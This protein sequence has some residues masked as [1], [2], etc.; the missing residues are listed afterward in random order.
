[1][2]CLRKTNLSKHN[3]CPHNAPTPT[4]KKE[5]GGNK[6]NSLESKNS[7]FST[8]SVAEEKW[9]LIYIWYIQKRIHGIL[10]TICFLA[11]DGA[12]MLR[13]MLDLLQV[14]N[15]YLKTYYFVLYLYNIIF[16]IIYITYLLCFSLYR[17]ISLRTRAFS[18][19]L[20][21]PP[22]CLYNSI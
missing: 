19:V 10:Q 3:H 5:G 4:P 18:S 11:R 2:I 12:I 6:L 14:K 9:L 1:M 13:G 8:L 16:N 22:K 17:V 15:N 20:K 21:R 7:L